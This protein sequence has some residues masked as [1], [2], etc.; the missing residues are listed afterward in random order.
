MD[1]LFNFSKSPCSKGNIGRQVAWGLT[2]RE[3]CA[4]QKHIALRRVQAVGSSY[5]VLNSY[6]TFYLWELGKIAY[7]SKLLHLFL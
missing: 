1:Y 3:K 5:L 4:E 6:C 7:F 2:L